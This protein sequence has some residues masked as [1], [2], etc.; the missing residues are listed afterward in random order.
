MVSL[1]DEMRRFLLVTLMSLLSISS[2]LFSSSQVLAGSHS[3]PFTP[4][5]VSVL[6]VSPADMNFKGGHYL[7][8]DLAR[9]GFDVTQHTSNDAIGV[10]YVTDPKTS[11]LDQYNVVILHGS[12]LGLPPSKV[13]AEEVDH[14]TDYR[15]L[16]ILIGTALFR[17][18]TSGTW[19]SQLFSSDPVQKMEQRLGVDFVDY[20]K[21]A[22]ATYFHNNG[23]F[24]VTNESIEGAPSNLT[25]ITTDRLGNANTQF[26]LTTTDA[27]NIYNFSTA[28]GKA[29][30][31]GVT[32]YNDTA[33]G[34]GI[35]IQGGYIYATSPAP[36]QISYLGLTDTGKRATLLASLIASAL[37]YDFG[38]IIKP[39]PLANVRLDSV[40][41][42]FPEQYLNASL[43]N[44][45]AV[46]GAYSIT[47]SVE[48]TDYLDFAPKYWQ[49]TADDVL[50]QLQREYTSW[51]YSSSLRRKD[52]RPMTEDQIEALIE[53][54]RGNYT[55]ELEIDL[56][57]TVVAPAGRWSQETLAAMT[58]EGLYLI[59]I[60]NYYYPD[61]WTLKVNSSIVV[62]SGVRMVPE[63]AG[64]KL[65]ENFTQTGLDQD[66]LHYK[67][68]SQR[69]KWALA[70]VNGFPSFIYHVSNFRWNQVGTYSLNTVYRN[71]TAEIPDIRFVP[72]VEAALY[73]GNKWM[74]IS[75]ASREGATIT[76]DLDSSAI[77]EV[78]GIGKGM[79]WLR[80]STV[81]SIREVMIDGEPWFY[82]DDHT[83]RLPAE[84]AHVKVILGEKL[85]PTV[86]RTVY[87]VTETSWDGELF[88]VSVAT[89]P[90]LNV[91][92]RL[93]TS[94]SDVICEENQWNFTYD[95]PSQILEFWA[96]SDGLVTLKIGAD[97][98]PP[99]I[100]D[101][102]WSITWYHAEVR[103][104]ANITDLNSGVGSANLSYSGGSDWRNVTMVR[105]DGVYR[106]GIPA[107]RYGTV[108]QFVLYVSDNAGN[109]RESETFSYNV[110]DVFPPEIGVPEWTPSPAQADQPVLV[111]VSVVEPENASG[112]DW[113]KLWYYLDGNSSNAQSVVMTYEDGL[114]RAEI[115]GQGG[116]KSVSFFV[117]AQDMT[118][119]NVGTTATYSF[120]VQEEDWWEDTLLLL[121]VVGVV[122]AGIAVGVGLYIARVR[123]T[124]PEPE[125]EEK[126]EGNE[127]ATTKG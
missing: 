110:T 104:W 72:L 86:R 52:V 21:N 33:T 101:V 93:S 44:F 16:L 114:W 118:G 81:E 66:A 99:V 42:Y 6:V 7:I 53:N 97:F 123:K 45:D 61:W 92:I 17:N 41:Q 60:P 25:Y 96:I 36:N 38:T 120:E 8:A 119:E 49:E 65:A 117:E 54:V 3:E 87:K 75:N 56:F 85:Y 126:Q 64:A 30:T 68:V 34:G 98:T 125:T 70:V 63:R 13:S 111:S 24:T 22:G 48:F 116:G 102:R 27:E 1:G 43:L 67:Y 4:H 23:T 77:P 115:P 12:S 20:L 47:P 127:T 83:V 28:D 107:F 2:F 18:E 35:Y 105:D 31:N 90:G 51:E 91:S 100:E 14:F 89:M 55:D 5:E 10:N 124:S 121:L 103:V 37:R 39:Q 15:G 94:A 69:D 9:Y 109:W 80:I 84:S 40:G 62:H 82:F 26:L 32:Y 95:G 79:V 113:V 57:N 58:N 74:R 76:F 88:S 19:W 29:T 73:F 122:G 78:V 46:T 59:D 108:V 11:N 71:L 106:G 112:L 50:R